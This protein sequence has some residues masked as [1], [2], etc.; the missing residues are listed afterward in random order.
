MRFIFFFQA[1][2]GIR[3]LYVTGVQTCALPISHHRI[4][5]GAPTTGEATLLRLRARPRRHAQIE[6]AAATWA[7]EEPN[8]RRLH[9][10]LP[11]AGDDRCAV[12]AAPALFDRGSPA[13]PPSPATRAKAA[14]PSRGR[15][16]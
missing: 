14:S 15:E 1:E 9:S 3:D 5:R 8:Q 6:P 11:S 16:K 2:D 10:A 7:D 4:P 12:S 13:N